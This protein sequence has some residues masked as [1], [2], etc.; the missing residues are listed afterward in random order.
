M[1]D[2]KSLH[3]DLHSPTDIPLASGLLRSTI[4]TDFI[5]LLGDDLLGDDFFADL[6]GEDLFVDLLG[7]DL[8]DERLFESTPISSCL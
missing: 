1:F 3:L 7:D 8:F 4:L 6:L 2:G 5:D